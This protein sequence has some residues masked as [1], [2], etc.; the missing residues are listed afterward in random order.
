[1]AR[2][3]QPTFQDGE[4]ELRVTQGEVCICGTPKGLVRLAELCAMLAAKAAPQH[5]HLEDRELLTSQS[6]RGTIA[7]FGSTD[8]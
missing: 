3:T 5:L 6:L 7:V 2:F 1:M 4:I 8:Q